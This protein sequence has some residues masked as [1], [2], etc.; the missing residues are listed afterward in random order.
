LVPPNHRPQSNYTTAFIHTN[1]LH[2]PNWEST[3]ILQ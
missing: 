2:L 3:I 1:E